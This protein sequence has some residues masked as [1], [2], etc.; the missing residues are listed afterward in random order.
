M[1]E[2]RCFLT[3]ASRLAVASVLPPGL[4]RPV[5]AT[6]PVRVAISVP[7]PGNLLFLPLP[8]ARRLG[9]D[10]AEGVELDIRYIG[11]GPL[12]YRAMLERNSDFATGGLAAL[13]LQRINGKPVTCIAPITQVPAYTLVVSRKLQRQVKVVADLRGRVVGVRGYVPGGRSTSQLFTEYLLQREGVRADQANFVAVGQDYPNQH[14]ALASGTVDAIM[15]DEPFASRLVQE[16]VA[17]VLA[18]FHDQDAVRK[19]LGGPFLNGVLATRD[20]VIASQPMLVEKMVKVLKRTLVWMHAR[21]AAE[22]TDAMNPSTPQERAALLAV[23][24]ARKNIYS[25]DGIISTEQVETV[26]RFVRATEQTA[27]AQAFN[28]HGMVDARWAGSSK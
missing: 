10:L 26:Q 21:S 13:A 6:T 27:A 22:M 11:G 19:L 12:A 1:N 16:K 7:G 28:L 23:L 5:Q 18:D 15:A 14:A 25:P 4:A 17:F 3:H 24:K 2:R 20:D 8:L 9:T